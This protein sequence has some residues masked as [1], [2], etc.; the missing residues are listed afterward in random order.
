M[1]RYI[2][3]EI[4]KERDIYTQI[5]G[6]TVGERLRQKVRNNRKTKSRISPSEDR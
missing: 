4:R 6:G 3:P 2:Q 5:T 1:D